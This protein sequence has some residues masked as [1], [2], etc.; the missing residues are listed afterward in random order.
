ML[1]TLGIHDLGLFMLTGL[2]LNLTPGA[3]TL[4]VVSRSAAGGWRQGA[5]AAL[6]IQLGCLVHATAAA[7]GVAALLAASAQAFR[8]LTWVGA[9]YLAW[10]GVKMLREGVWP[11]R[12]AAGAGTNGAPGSAI[13][14]PRSARNAF[15]QGLLTNVLNPK[16]GL[17]FLAFV[18]Q[19]IRPDAAS[20]VAA[21]LT[22][23]VVFD[24]TGGTWLMIVAALTVRLRSAVSPRLGRWL[25]GL[26]GALFLGL[27][28]R[29]ATDRKGV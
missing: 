14:A 3:D 27:A 24:L 10:L 20:P 11:A 22:L 26:G 7:L 2:V 12:A 1:H 21:F 17:F 29:L 19:F 23:G 18:P 8:V 25:Q 16:V 15:M 13:A 9:A 4:L 28:W 6:G 5:L